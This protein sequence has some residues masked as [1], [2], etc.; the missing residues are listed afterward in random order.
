MQDYLKKFKMSRVLFIKIF[1]LYCSLS[2]IT[3]LRN[4]KKMR[5][6]GS[7]E[8]QEPASPKKSKKPK[9]SGG[10]TSSG[11]KDLQEGT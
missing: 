7:A 9:A 2:F 3:V 10:I 4:I 1:N 5:G 11:K 6:Q 8:D